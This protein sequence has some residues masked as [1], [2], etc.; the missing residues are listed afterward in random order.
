MGP[1]SDLTQVFQLNEYL[2]D[3]EEEEEDENMTAKSP[4]SLFWT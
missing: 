4:V 3:T 2:D 1:Q